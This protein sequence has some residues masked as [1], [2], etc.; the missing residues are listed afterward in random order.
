MTKKHDTSTGFAAHAAETDALIVESEVR[1]L[2]GDAGKK[3]VRGLV[4]LGEFNTYAQGGRTLYSRNEVQNYIARLK[5]RG[6]S[7]APWRGNGGAAGGS[8]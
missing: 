7:R 8:R 1:E 6:P 2:L 4:E 3:K 5:A